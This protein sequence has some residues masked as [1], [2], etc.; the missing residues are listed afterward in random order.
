[1]PRRADRSASMLQ[2]YRHALESVALSLGVGDEV[3]RILAGPAQQAIA[4]ARDIM[5]RRAVQLA[6]HEAFGDGPVGRNGSF[7]TWRLRSMDD[8]FG[9]VV[10]ES[11]GILVAVIG[12]AVIW[13]GK[14]VAWINECR[15]RID[16]TEIGI[17]YERDRHK[18]ID[19][20][21]DGVLSGMVRATCSPTALWIQ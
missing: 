9:H 14:K 3:R 17:K 6:T 1:M 19:E 5:V 21:L 2:Q 13:K 16:C 20:M 8:R 11:D 10:L 12:A 4:A 15:C 18:E 7:L